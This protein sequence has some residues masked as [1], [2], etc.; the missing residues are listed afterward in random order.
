MR[1]NQQRFENHQSGAI[2]AGKLADMPE[3]IVSKLLRAT[4]WNSCASSIGIWAVTR[5]S[6]SRTGSRFISAAFSA[7]HKIQL[8]TC[9]FVP[10]PYY[11]QRPQR[12]MNDWNIERR[13]ERCLGQQQL[14]ANSIES[15]VSHEKTNLLSVTCHSP[16]LQTTKTFLT[17]SV[18]QE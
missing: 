13:D 2:C 6:F 11:T 16:Y 4:I 9:W 5:K 12:P 17:Q 8:A 7:L 14:P 10:M 1:R 15:F 3:I 18:L